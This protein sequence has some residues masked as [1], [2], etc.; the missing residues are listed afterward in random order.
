MATSEG[1]ELFV[2]QFEESTQWRIYSPEIVLDRT[3]SEKQFLTEDLGPPILD[4]V[5]EPG[6]LL[7]IPRGHIYHA[8]R[9]VGS[10]VPASFLCLSTY[11]ENAWCDLLSNSLTSTLARLSEADLRFREG[12]PLNWTS[13]FGAAISET[14]Q[15]CESRRSFLTKMKLLLNELVDSVIADIDDVA[16]EMGS[17]F[18]ALRTPPILRKRANE[19][20]VLFGPDPRTFTNG[21]EIRLRNP[22]WI[23]LVKDGDSLVLFTCID[24]KV[25]NHRT[26][27]NPA[28]AEPTSIELDS[29]NLEGIQTLIAG[30][31]NTWCSVNCLNRQVVGTLWENA[32]LESRDN[33]AKKSRLD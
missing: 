14:E 4:V 19:K 12:L 26:I 28:E 30:W 6:E 32:I 13:M 18:V 24:N 7:Y 2:L 31:P 33:T 27:D 15:N 10:F 1:S 8:E 5:L 20:T 25:V 22:S 17:D 3:T 21:G 29:E 16:D 23:R 9:L 11:Q